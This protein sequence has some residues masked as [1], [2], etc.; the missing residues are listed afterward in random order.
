MMSAKRSLRFIALLAVPFSFATT[1][2]G[3][4]PNRLGKVLKW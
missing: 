3:N 4:T 2:E 1:D